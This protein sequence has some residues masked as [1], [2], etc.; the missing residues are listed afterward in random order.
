MIK[1]WYVEISI[2]FFI[3]FF[4]FFLLFTISAFDDM[5]IALVGLCSTNFSLLVS[6]LVINP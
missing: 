6:L 4:I 5:K 2:F 1:I 3:F